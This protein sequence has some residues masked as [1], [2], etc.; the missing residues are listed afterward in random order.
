M[1]LTAEQMHTK[2]YHLGENKPEVLKGGVVRRPMAAIGN[3][4]FNICDA[5]P[6]MTMEIAPTPQEVVL[7]FVDGCADL[8]DGRVVR[9]DEA[10]IQCP[11]T[12]AFLKFVGVEG[13]RFYEIRVTPWPGA[14]PLKPELMKFPVRVESVTPVRRPSTGTFARTIMETQSTA[15]TICEN[16]PV[17][18][19]NDPGHPE[20]EIVYVLKGKL[21]YLNG[22]GRVVRPGECVTNIPGMPHPFRYAG[23]EP[24]RYLEILSPPYGW[25]KPGAKRKK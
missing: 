2:V 24:I 22:P 1:A 3:I 6:G 13:I 5:M 8:D 10:I 15:V 14:D 12:R 7:L 25:P 16:R 4:T 20:N 9:A 23:T 17:V 18:E 21:E 11:N 19:M